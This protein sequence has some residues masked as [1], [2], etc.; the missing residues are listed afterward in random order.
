MTNSTV[1][2]AC[3]ACGSPQSAG[4]RPGAT[5]TTCLAC[6][7]HV[8]A[9]L[10]PRT[11]APHSPPPLPRSAPTP[12]DAV[13]FYDATQKATCLC[14]QCGVLVSDAWSAH[15]GNRKVCLRCLDKLR[16]TKRD[17]SFESTRLM[18]DNIC[19]LLS[20]AIL[21]VIFPYFAIVTAPTA[22]ILGIRH[23]NHPRSL[24]PRSRFRLIAALVFASLQIIAMLVGLYLLIE[25]I[26]TT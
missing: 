23:W 2:L 11:F 17:S 24:I 1:W 8:E 20:S 19:L 3:P 13:C 21:I 22:L 26:I 10:L 16:E 6:R 25:A 7:K 12:G 18:W 15:W 14:D 9:L 5:A 4:F